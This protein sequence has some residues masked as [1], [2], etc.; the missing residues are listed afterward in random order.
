MESE[1]W[2]EYSQSPILNIKTKRYNMDF[3]LNQEHF[4]NMFAVPTVVADK[5]LKLSNEAQLKVLLYILKNGV[6]N[7]DIDSIKRATGLNE[8][9]I[10]D[11]ITYWINN[12]VFVSLGA[13][14][15]T[16]TT[17]KKTAVLNIQKPSRDEIT[18]R[19]IEDENIAFLLQQAQ[20]KFGRMLKQNE[21][22]T[23]VWL[24]DNEGLN[25]SVILMIIEY[26]LSEDRLTAGFIEQTAV[27]WIND[28]VTDVQSADKQIVKMRNESQAWKTVC[29]VMGIEKRKP[30]KKEIEAV[31]NWVSEWKFSRE[32]L[33]AAYDE[34]V[35]HTQKY[36]W[37][38][39]NSILLAWHKNGIKTPD[40]IN[41]KTEDKKINRNK[42]SYSIDEIEK[43]LFG[44]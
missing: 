29:A 13:K 28:G 9:D 27:K 32:M 24:Y 44:K 11:S 26:A 15:Q 21:A 3:A 10:N 14:V 42:E 8:R 40:D 25:I 35:D 22:S 34:C 41:K 39:I 33:K 37:Q 17:E 19:G 23:L 1:H 2:S 5:H 18:K 4:L 43:I 7:F 12:G 30:S 36:S 31:M 6:Q 16:T 38:Y 20:I